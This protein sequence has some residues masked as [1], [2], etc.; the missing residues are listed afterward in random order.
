MSLYKRGR[1]WW[2]RLTIGGP[3]IRESTGTTDKE[4][5][6]EYLAKRSTELWRAHHLGERRTHWDEATLA[7]VEQHAVHKGSYAYDLAKLRWLQPYLTG[8]ALDSVDTEFLTELRG[9]KQAEGFSA[10]TANRHLSTVSAVLHYAKAR[11]KLTHVPKIPYLP[12]E[13]DRFLW[14][15]R[16]QAKALIAE[17]PEHLARMSRFVLATGLRRA[18][19]TGLKWDCVD[20]GRRVAWVWGDEAKAGKAFP[21]PL[22]DD[23]IAVLRECWG[24]HSES[25]FTYKKKDPPGKPGHFPPRPVHRVKTAAWDKAVKRAKLNPA[26]RFH[27][28]RHTWA[29]WHVMNGTP[30]EVLMRLGGWAS[31]DMVLRYAHLA[32]GYLSSY[33]DASSF[34]PTLSGGDGGNKP[35]ED[36]RTI[37]GTVE[38]QDVAPLGAKSLKEMGWLMGFE[39]T[40]TGITSGS[41]DNV[42]E[43]NQAVSE[44]RLVS[45]RRKKG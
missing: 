41:P 17:L 8:R 5:A 37:S 10:A 13:T 20:I 21:V 29:S 16:D 30:L 39:P 23:A 15:T 7:W 45:R 34:D 24:I 40:T 1:I 12:E 9:I 22:N 31:I 26:F 25:V 38:M 27:D 43:L 3:E 11:G 33:A 6:K 44:T 19:V 14:I 36:F 35:C 32:P 42:V 18:N 2:L 4:A 28:L